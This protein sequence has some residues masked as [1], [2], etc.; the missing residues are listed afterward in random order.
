ML[1]NKLL[2]IPILAIITGVPVVIWFTLF[3]K[4]SNISKWVLILI[5][6]LGTLTAPTLLGIQYLWQIFPQFDVASLIE[7]SITKVSLMYTVL[8]VF[9]GMMEEVIKHFV[10][11]IVDKKT[12]AIKTVNDALRFSI[13]AGLGFSFAENIYYLY[14]LWNNIGIGELVGIFL[15]RSAF[16]MCAHMIFSGIFGYYFGISKFSIDIAKQNELSGE[17]STAARVISKFFGTNLLIGY[18]EK[19][20]LKGL[21]ISI[22]LHACFNFLLQFNVIIPVVLFVI[23]GYLYLRY[24]LK[25]KAG[26]LVLFTDISEKKSSM[27]AKKDEEV[28][29]ELLG[30]WFKEK[31][32]VDVIHVCERLL[33]RDQDN[34]VVKLFKAKALDKIENKNVYKKILETIFENKNEEKNKDKENP[35]TDNKNLLTKYI[36]QKKG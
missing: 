7:I 32:Y 36:E 31:R 27:L 16:T 9:F 25:S 33:Q 14:S 28:V 23:L 17:K 19:T 20:I 15:F 4:Q 34:N 11:R 22:G 26:H 21:F 3:F 10:V 30:M 6:F 2:L 29:L 1:E 18:R 24:L 35:P 13:L 12:T 8:F 5:F